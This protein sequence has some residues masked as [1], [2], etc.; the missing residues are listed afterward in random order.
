MYSSIDY[1]SPRL[2]YKK[3]RQHAKEIR[4]KEKNNWNDVHYDYKLYYL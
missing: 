3:L 4:Q 1:D 2:T